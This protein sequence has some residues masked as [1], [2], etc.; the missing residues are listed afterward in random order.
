MVGEKYVLRGAFVVPV[1]GELDLDTLAP[2]REALEAA[3]AEHPVTV[4]DGAGIT[5]ADSSALNLLL[6]TA[7]RTT[8]RIAAPSASLLRLLRLTGADQVLRTWPTVDDAADAD[9]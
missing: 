2:L 5:F 7:G 6:D 9:S 4:L 8:L 3:A 1:R